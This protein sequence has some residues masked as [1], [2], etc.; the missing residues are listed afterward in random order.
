MASR[1]SSCIWE[2]V[3]FIQ[4]SSYILREQDTLSD[5]LHLTEHKGK[6]IL[7]IHVCI[8]IQY[9]LTIGAILCR[10]PVKD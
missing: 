10:S 2:G 8:N 6:C 5:E 9:S 7:N 3:A 4:N 1:L